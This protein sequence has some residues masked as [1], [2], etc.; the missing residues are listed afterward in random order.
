MVSSTLYQH[1][2]GLKGL[3]KRPRILYGMYEEGGRPIFLQAHYKMALGGDGL[4]DYY[5]YHKE[6]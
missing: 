1:L 3:A 6:L 2:S 5:V 4:C